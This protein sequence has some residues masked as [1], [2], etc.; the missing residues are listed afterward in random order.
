MSDIG[1]CEVFSLGYIDVAYGK[2]YII[3]PTSYW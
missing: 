3:L 1:L 2:L